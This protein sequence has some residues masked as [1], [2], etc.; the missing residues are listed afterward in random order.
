MG[1]LSGC[2]TLQPPTASF[3]ALDASE[4]ASDTSGMAKAALEADFQQALV[5]C[6]AQMSAMREAFYGSGKT[7]LTIASVGIVAGSIIV[8]ALAAKTAAARSAI[9]GWGGVSGAANAAQYTLQQKGVS[10]ARLGAVY[11]SIRKEIQDST[12]DYA[13]ATK[14]SQRIVAVNRLSVACRYPQ[15]PVAEAPRP[16]AAAS[17]P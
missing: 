8:P 3:N 16:D 7:E 5:Q 10:A 4:R 14:N 1:L 11:E 12:H 6:D 2:S 9:A 15:L 13:A 17:A